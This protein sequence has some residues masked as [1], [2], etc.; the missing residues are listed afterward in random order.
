MSAKK[1]TIVAKAF[2]PDNSPRSFRAT[3]LAKQFAKEGHQ[4]TVFINE[5]DFDYTEFEREH[6]LTIK[7]YGRLKFKPLRS[8]GTRI[9]EMK[10]K[11]G[12][13]L[14]MLMDYPNIEIT[15]KVKAA[16]KNLE[17]QDLLI[18]I[19][20]PYAVHWGVAWARTKE[21]PLAKVWAADC[22][23]PFMGNTLES[24]R[25]PFYFSFLEKWFCRKA[26]YL[27]VPTAGA[28]DSYYKEFHGKIRVIPQGFN[29]KDVEITPGEVRNEVPTFAY[30]GGIAQTGVRSPFPLLNLL[31][32]TD[33]NFV[34]HIYA[35]NN[36]HLLENKLADYGGRVGLHKAVPRKELLAHLAKM[37]FLVNLDNGT[38]HQV[39]SKLID[40][41]LT[42]RP[43]LNIQPAHPDPALIN[44][45]LNGDYSRQ[46]VLKNLQDYDITNVCKSFL[47]LANAEINGE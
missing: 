9:G 6:N 30:S 36:H 39:P 5:K 26:E 11:L 27:T 17:K 4:V 25:Y 18:S 14:F 37:D 13:L 46:W 20:V 19:A 35:T 38:S 12:R 10:R 8:N 41:S 7:S 23:D 40:Y 29:F 42:G 47:N 16:L 44:E 3:E 43:I 1:I 32:K 15:W 34:F 24:F 21:N 2:Y 22:G 45:F 33:K 31:S 28:I